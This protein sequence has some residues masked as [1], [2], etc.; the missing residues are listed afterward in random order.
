MADWRKLWSCISTSV[1]FNGLLDKPKLAEFA[2]LV[3]V[4]AIAHQDDYGRLSG[5]V[6]MFKLTVYPASPRGL[7]NFTA[8]LDLLS[9]TAG[10]DGIPLITWDRSAEVVQINK[11]DTWQKIGHRPKASKYPN[12]VKGQAKVDKSLSLFPDDKTE[13]VGESRQ[14][15]GLKV[16]VLGKK[17][18][19]L[20]I[21][22]LYSYNIIKV[23][24]SNVMDNGNDRLLDNWANRI[25]H[26]FADIS[27][28]KF[29]SQ[30]YNSNIKARILEGNSIRTILI[31][32]NYMSIIWRPGK[33]MR[34]YLSPA[35]IFRQRNF[36]KYRAA[37]LEWWGLKRE[38]K[39]LNRIR[40]RGEF[41]NKQRERWY[42]ARSAVIAAEDREEK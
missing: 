25:V 14:E 42:E 9:R 15:G 7:D 31:T 5:N 38:E 23:N 2:Q 35:T 12:I 8:A 27:G 17:A 13:K 4:L 1:A 16:D 11:W 10:P 36:P 32:L 19:S 24:K 34:I 30:A 37:A 40:L 39:E 29:E 41:T 28:R 33:K 20:L 21:L 26:K 22:L 6:R 18:Y 3:Y